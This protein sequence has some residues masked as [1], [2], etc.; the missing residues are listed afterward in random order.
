MRRWLTVLVLSLFAALVVPSLALATHSNGQGPGQDFISGAAKGTLPTPCGVFPAQF[1]DN[2]Q[3]QDNVSN[4]ATGKFWVEITFNPPCLG[5]TTADFSGDIV[6]LNAYLGPAG[7]LNSS[8]HVGLID[9][10][11]LNP[12][13]VGGIPGL[14][15]P[16]MGTLTRHVDNGSPGA[17]VDRSLGFTT[18]SPTPCGAGSLAAPFSTLPIIQGNLVTHKG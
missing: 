5:F 3:A 2:A 17:G 14:L 6:C 1:H 12:G 13:G 18:P 16:G 8:N 9:F 15:F 7:Q 10:V 4:V 11:E